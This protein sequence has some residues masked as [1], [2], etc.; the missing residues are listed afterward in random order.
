MAFFFLFG[1]ALSNSP[2]VIFPVLGPYFTCPLMFAFLACV[3][4]FL[5]LGLK[6][7]SLGPLSITPS[8]LRLPWSEFWLVFAD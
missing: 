1:L 3:F 5:L 7:I 6:V 4:H 8:G 2:P